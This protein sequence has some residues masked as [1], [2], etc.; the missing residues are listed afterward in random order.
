[1]TLRNRPFLAARSATQV[2]IEGSALASG[3][4]QTR[5]VTLPRDLYVYRDWV[6]EDDGH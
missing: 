3:A 6:S 4:A 5:N 2:V 1:M